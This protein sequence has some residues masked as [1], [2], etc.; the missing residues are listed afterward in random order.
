[1]AS[2]DKDGIKPSVILGAAGGVLVLF[3]AGMVASSYFDS[4]P[5]APE[6]ISM[7]A[8]EPAAAPPEAPEISD[9][10]RTFF[11]KGN[12]EECMQRHLGHDSRVEGLLEIELLPDGTVANAGTKSEPQNA[13]VALCIQQRFARGFV[14]SG[15]NQ[16]VSYTF[17]ARWDGGRLVMGQ[18]VTST[19]K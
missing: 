18:N 2:N 8:I 16:K 17:N 7:S 9:R 15:P 19:G 1:M 6:K 13:G 5:T 14:F 3:A 11:M 4:R 10:I 12:V